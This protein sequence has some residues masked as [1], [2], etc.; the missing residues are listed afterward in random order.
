MVV[1]IN[2]GSLKWMVYNGK[3]H[4]N[5]WFRGYPY[6]RKLPFLV[7][8]S[9]WFPALHNHTTV[10]EFHFRASGNF[11]CLETDEDKALV[12][13]HRESRWKVGTSRF[14]TVAKLDKPSRST[15]KSSIWE[16]IVASDLVASMNVGRS[17][18]KPW[19]FSWCFP[20]NVQLKSQRVAHHQWRMVSAAK[21]HFYRSSPADGVEL[22]SALITSLYI[23]IDHYVW[24]Y[25]I[26]YPHISLCIII[27]YIIIYPSESE[28]S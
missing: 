10:G 2:G 25:I 22:S 5:R 7:S 24:L 19:V 23:I 20:Q 27:L 15:T 11:L 17:G 14:W 13:E 8:N 28:V 9:V 12:N 3:S 1:S 6:F 4:F 21:P 18:F 26:M 16:M